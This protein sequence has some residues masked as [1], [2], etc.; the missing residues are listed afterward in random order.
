MTAVGNS[1]LG[2][3]FE[4]AR[5]LRVFLKMPKGLTFIRVEGGRI[6]KTTDTLAWER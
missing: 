1:G 4:S 6:C 5:K 3:G 2:P